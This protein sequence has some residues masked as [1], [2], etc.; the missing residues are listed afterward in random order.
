MT[1]NERRTA[2]AAGALA[3]VLFTAGCAPLLIGG[4]AAGGAMVAADRRS[5]GT[6]LED[7]AIELRVSKAL[8]NAF[9]GDRAHIN[10]TSYNLRV[11]LT[12]EVR[13]EQ[14][15]AEAQS[16]AQKSENVRA[17]V[18]ELYIG[19]P[20]TLA[21]RNF[22]T[23]LT[24]K[25]LAALL[26]A[27]DVPSGA[28]KVVSERAVVYLMG[29]V[30]PGEGDAAARSASR[31]AGVQRVVKVFDYLTDKEAAALAGK[32]AEPAAPVK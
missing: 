32:P 5:A 23:A 12:G 4:A 19:S 13:N 2:L 1:T 10:A 22:D 26:Q 14:D 28:I 7:Q 30:T 8:S 27:P 24:A 29:R 15:K 31:V 3:A 16:I 9:P 21:N 6:Q 18:N 11:L 17:V 25:V 20:S